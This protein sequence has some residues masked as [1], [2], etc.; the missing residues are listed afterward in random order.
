MHVENTVTSFLGML[1]PMASTARPSHCMD[2]LKPFS[3]ST[4]S[5]EQSFYLEF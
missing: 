5:T 3:G 2:T 4:S 1:E